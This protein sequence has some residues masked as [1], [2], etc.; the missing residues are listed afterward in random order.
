MFHLCLL[1]REDLAVSRAASR[2]SCE[3]A[4][5][6]VM[7]SLPC[8][9]SAV[10]QSSGSHGPAIAAVHS[11]HHHTAPVQPHG[12]QVVQSHAHPTPPAVPVQGQQQFQRLKVMPS[13]APFFYMVF[14]GHLPAKP[15]GDLLKAF[16]ARLL[17]FIGPNA[18]RDFSFCCN[19]YYPLSLQCLSQY[20]NKKW[21]C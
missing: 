12:S 10:P 6:Y 13:I 5:I 4:A 3:A 20:C 19:P 16:L 11:G 7:S 18:E 9:V 1:V 17:L 14:G 2:G 21:T 15:A 8:Q